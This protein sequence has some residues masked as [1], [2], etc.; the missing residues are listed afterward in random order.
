MLFRSKILYTVVVKNT[1]TGVHKIFYT[2]KGEVATTEDAKFVN[3]EVTDYSID[4]KLLG[5]QGSFAVRDG[6]VV[7]SYTK[8]GKT[9]TDSEDLRPNLTIGPHL[10][11]IL[12][13]NWDLIMKGETLQTRYG[14]LERKE[15]VGFK[16][17][18]IDEKVMP[19]F[20]SKPVVLIR[21][22]SSSLVISALVDPLTFICEKDGSHLLQVTGRTQPKIQKDGKWQDLDVDL[23][24]TY[25]R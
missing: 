9:E 3:G 8:N 4:Q 12:R 14:A 23:V 17:F 13:K 22:K 2:P 19:E 16:F 1:D 25:G 24:Y 10:M 15:T 18:K 7:F 21:M 5:E 11:T 20:G 6:K